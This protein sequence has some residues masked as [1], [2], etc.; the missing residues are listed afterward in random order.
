MDPNPNMNWIEQLSAQLGM[1]PEY[2]TNPIVEP[3]D[4]DLNVTYVLP[5]QISYIGI[6]PV[7]PMSVGS[8]TATN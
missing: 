1:T 3:S 6:V 7:P 4:V 5:P 2:A 8:S